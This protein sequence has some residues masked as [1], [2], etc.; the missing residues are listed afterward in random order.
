MESLDNFPNLF[1]M[2]TVTMSHTVVSKVPILPYFFIFNLKKKK[3]PPYK[4]MFEPVLVVW[5]PRPSSLLRSVRVGRPG[6]LLPPVAG[7]APL[8]HRPGRAHEQEPVSGLLAAGGLRGD[9]DRTLDPPER[10]A[11]RYT[12]RSGSHGPSGR[13]L[14]VAERGILCFPVV[15]RVG[16]GMSVRG[17]GLPDVYHTIQLHFHWGGPASNGSEHTV[18]RRRY[19]MEVESVSGATGPPPLRAPP[20]FLSPSRCTW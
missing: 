14:F 19:P 5:N 12:P 6:P 3:K 1:Q 4:G 10:R 11:F 7:R 18:E 17:G 16:S 15:L 13:L 8:A 20:L 2:T 9:P